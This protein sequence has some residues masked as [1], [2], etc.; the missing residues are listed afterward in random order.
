[1]ARRNDG[2]KALLEWAS[3]RPDE[4]RNRE[5]L[6]RFL[7]PPRSISE[8]AE[9]LR[10][11]YS[12]VAY[13]F[14]PWVPPLSHDESIL[15][16]RLQFVR[17]A[18]ELGYLTGTVGKGPRVT[19][20]RFRSIGPVLGCTEDDVDHYWRIFGD[21]NEGYLEGEFTRLG[22]SSGTLADQGT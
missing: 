13:M 21:V 4:C 16:H 22:F 18:V 1:M 17:E 6:R 19:Q 2:S 10:A 15:Q 11:F 5:T 12:S 8:Y 14:P 7:C 20:K 9:G 3:I